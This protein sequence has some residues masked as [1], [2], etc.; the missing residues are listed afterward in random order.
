MLKFSGL[1]RVRGAHYPIQTF[2]DTLLQGTDF[3][4][5]VNKPTSSVKGALVQAFADLT[6]NLWM[7]TDEMKMVVTTAPFKS[8]IQRFAPRFMGYQQQDVQ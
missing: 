8:R 7:K 2:L 5:E 1:V 3:S 4:S 6:Q